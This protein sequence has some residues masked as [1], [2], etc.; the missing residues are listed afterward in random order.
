MNNSEQEDLGVKHDSTLDR[1]AN[2]FVWPH[3]RLPAP[4]L[5]TL[6]CNHLFSLPLALDTGWLA[7]GQL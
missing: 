2:P 3:I 7:H 6:V 1:A 5:L 4:A